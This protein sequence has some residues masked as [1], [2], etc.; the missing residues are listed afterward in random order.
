MTPTSTRAALVIGLMGFAA[1]S[2]GDAIVK[3]MAGE[4]P[5]TA[6]SPRR[7]TF[8]A[9]GLGM[10]ISLLIF[11]SSRSL[12]RG[13]GEP[14]ESAQQGAAWRVYLGSIAGVAVSA[15]LVQRQ[16]AVGQLLVLGAA[17]WSAWLL[18]LAV[19]AFSGA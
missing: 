4:W 10:A 2:F 17:L 16:E 3:S 9:A 7:Y 19:L 18:F 14:P 15:W 8:G 6:V 11:V 1:F 12:L 5:G 13:R